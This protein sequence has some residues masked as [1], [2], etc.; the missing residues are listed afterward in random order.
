MQTPVHAGRSTRV[1]L[2][3]DAELAV[4]AAALD[5]G[6]QGAPR[7]APHGDDTTNGHVIMVRGEAG[8]GK[9]SLLD[10]AMRRAYGRR[11]L[12][13]SADVMDRRRTYGILL[14]AFAPVLTDD[15]RRLAAV[16]DKYAVAE[17]LL[18]IVDAVAVEPTVVVLEDL[19]WADKSS[20]ALLTRLSHTLEQLPLLIVGSMRSQAPR[21][22]PHEL[23]RLL[24][25]LSDRD[26]LTTIELGTLP[27]E[28]CV[29]IAECLAG[30]RISGT[31]ER[32]VGTAGGNPLFLT[33]MMRALLR[34]GA[35][36]IG[37]RGEARLDAPVGPSP[38]LAMVMM[39]H[40]SHLSSPSRDLL[41]TAALLGTRF[42][43]SQLRVVVD[44]PMSVLVP[45]LQ[46]T[47]A[48]GFLEDAEQDMLGFRHELI[49]EVLLQDLPAPVRAEL[50]R[51]I[52]IRLEAADVSPATV[53]GHLLQ[54][55]TDA[56][57]LPR[58]LRLAQRTAVSAPETAVEL[59]NRVIDATT[60][61]DP[62]NTQAVAGLARAALSS[63]R[64]VDA[65]D[66]A[67]VVLRRDVPP[68]SLAG[69]TRTLTQSLLLQHR[70]ADAR[71]AADRYA[72]A[73][74]LEPYDRAT[75]L[76]FAGWPRMMLGDVDGALRVAR[77]GAAMAAATG[78]VGAEV[79]ALSLQGQIANCRGDLDAAIVA[80]TDAAA[81][82][83]RH[84][85]LSTLETF[86][87]ALLAVALAD[88]GR[89]DA[90]V[91]LLQ[92]SLELAENL[93]YRT[94][95][96]AAHS[97]GAQARSRTGALS[98]LA[99][100]LDAHG[101]M[102]ASMDVRLDAPVR[103]IRAYVVAH[104]R[105]PGA[106]LEWSA[107][108]DPVPA[109]SM[110]GGRGRSWIW[111]G[112]SQRQR[113]AGDDSATFDVLWEGWR[114]LRAVRAE[115]DAAEIA[116]DL[117]D[118][119]RSVAGVHPSARAAAAQRSREVVDAV[120]TLADRNPDVAHLRA[121]ALAV[122]GVS[123]DDADLLLEA[124]G[125]MATTPR[126]FE[127]ARVSELAAL[128]LPVGHADSRSLAETS[129]RGYSDVGADHDVIRARAAFRRKGIAVLAPPRARPATGW[130]SLTRTE[131][132]IASRVATGATNPEIAANLSV[133]RRTVETHVSNVLAKLGLRSRTELAVFVSRRLDDVGQDG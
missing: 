2:G 76:A 9:T 116:L 101:A 79:I 77:D 97:L 67:A 50:H 33:E 93:G 53:A 31:L 84:P 111:Q 85:S 1:F 19:Q 62:L 124:A 115:V 35:V 83:D 25:A 5:R 7:R 60:S 13:A 81:K 24:V 95:M 123:T 48:A 120:A 122:E 88:A 22:T 66:L 127:H 40:L 59:W 39:R 37:P 113:A 46:E 128:A 70:H 118:L 130:E 63:G 64:V 21:E 55:P 32:Y 132:R 110:W 105:G 90:I 45:M 109:W 23:D 6:T 73:E 41:R 89:T 14:D 43:L 57:D 125:M 8:I 71:D 29:A 100:E 82:A 34:D 36:T 18:T 121:T 92:H 103:G 44:Q 126:R 74:V 112:V 38:S 68:E 87:H 54:A 78:N 16:Q 104:Q 4:L 106:A 61:D 72:A 12:Q 119:A 114:E 65:A 80:L 94:G 98:D 51:E 117:V 49:Q 133:S 11:V 28:T 52:A 27:A 108:L 107:S 96:L 30:G 91:E 75:H 42:S 26:L 58:M 10:A 99:A 131:E 102:V 47:F 56:P 15:D 17:R 129:L 20:L 69:V 86:P 3:R